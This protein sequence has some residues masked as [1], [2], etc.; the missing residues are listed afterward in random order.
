[1]KLHYLDDKINYLFTVIPV[2][3]EPPLGQLLCSV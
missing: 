1:V 3:T 2:K